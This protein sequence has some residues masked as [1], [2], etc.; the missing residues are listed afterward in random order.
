M[1][2][3]EAPPQTIDEALAAHVRERL[4]RIREVM[5]EHAESE[6]DYALD[7]IEDLTRNPR[8]Y[9]IE[10]VDG[11]S[12]EGCLPVFEECE[13]YVPVGDLTDAEI[14]A[15]ATRALK[16]TGCDDVDTEPPTI[17]WRGHVLMLAEHNPHEDVMFWF[18]RVQPD[19]RA[20]VM[21]CV[22]TSGLVTSCHRR[23]GD[24]RA[25]RHE[26]HA[27]W[28]PMTNGADDGQPAT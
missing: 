22:A 18:R 10:D 23:T 20:I 7:A 27:T 17:T 25:C 28:R 5:D 16:E 3:T 21:A 15:K 12:L 26:E 9:R 2:A 8:Y 13:V 1:S 4:E 14:I 19:E 11:L 6:P 24:M